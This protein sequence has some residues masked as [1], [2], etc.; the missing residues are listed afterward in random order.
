MYQSR[1]ASSYP[2][3]RGGFSLFGT[4]QP[5]GVS[6][7]GDDTFTSWLAQQGADIQNEYYSYQAANP[8]SSVVPSSSTSWLTNWMPFALGGLLLA[9][10]V[11][12]PVRTR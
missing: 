3:R 12:P 7:L 9:M 11:L 10:L 5:Q 6:G 2:Q 1:G 8:G 4:N